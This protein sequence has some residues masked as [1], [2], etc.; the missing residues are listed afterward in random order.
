M[1]CAT[2]VLPTLLTLLYCQAMTRSLHDKDLG[3]GWC[4]SRHAEIRALE[5]DIDTH[6]VLETLL[7][8]EVKYPD[9]RGGGRTRFVRGD[10]LVIAVPDELIVITVLHRDEDGGVFATA[11]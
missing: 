4:A 11:A 2:L 10:V 5:R 6:R 3:A 8:P 7:S 9:C 1:I